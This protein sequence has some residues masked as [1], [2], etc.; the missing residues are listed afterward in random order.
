MEAKIKEIS[1]NLDLYRRDFIR[2]LEAREQS[3]RDHHDALRE[4]HQKLRR[5]LAVC[6]IRKA[7]QDCRLN[8]KQCSVR[9]RDIKMS[10]WEAEK[11]LR[12]AVQVW[13][14]FQADHGLAVSLV[15]KRLKAAESML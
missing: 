3:Q 14:D 13:Q 7:R 1:L 2:E 12:A 9:L 10:R 11:G 8:H 5:E 15:T 6:Q 4:E